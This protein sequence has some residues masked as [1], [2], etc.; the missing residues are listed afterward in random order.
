MYN[1]LDSSIFISV[2]D[3]YAAVLCARSG[4]GMDV[5]ELYDYM[6]D[7]S[8]GDENDSGGVRMRTFYDPDDQT[9]HAEEAHDK[10][11]KRIPRPPRKKFPTSFA[12]RGMNMI[13]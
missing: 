6:T 3:A 8:S 9:I 4:Q 2:K 1:F 10:T 13:L 12:A 11:K 7:E 5:D